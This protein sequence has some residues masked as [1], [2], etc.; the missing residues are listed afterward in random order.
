MAVIA[1]LSSGGRSAAATFNIP[2]G[3]VT[4]LVNAIISADTNNQDDTINLASNGA[5]I[6]MAPDHGYDGLPA[7]E[8]DNSHNVTINGNGATI[9]RS[10]A[11][12]TLDFRIL[13]VG[14]AF[15]H[16]VTISNLT[17]NGFLSVATGLTGGALAVSGSTTFPCFSARLPITTRFAAALSPTPAY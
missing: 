17:M 9:M 12:G 3:N 15:G 1:S 16:T 13:T 7:I 14:V 4:A 8:I 11:S 2:D 10:S 6:I 5:Y